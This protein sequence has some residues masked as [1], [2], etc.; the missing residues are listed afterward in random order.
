MASGASVVATTNVRI[1]S[2]ASS[3]RPGCR[4]SA[5]TTSTSGLGRLTA[6]SRTWIEESL[7]VTAPAGRAPCLSSSSTMSHAAPGSPWHAYTSAVPRPSRRGRSI[8]WLGFAPADSRSSMFF[9]LDAMAPACSGVAPS[10]QV[11][12]TFAPTAIKAFTV[13]GPASCAAAT[14]IGALRRAS[15]RELS[16]NA[17]H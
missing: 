9:T 11:T 5:R 7:L 15:S 16:T 12:C 14:K 13:S 8:S 17:A 1:T 3:T 2:V 6:T 4:R 10:G